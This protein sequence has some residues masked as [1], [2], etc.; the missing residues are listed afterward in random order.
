M[1]RKLFFSATCLLFSHFAFSQGAAFDY[2]DDAFKYSD[3]TQN[4]TARFRGIGGNHAALGGD[5]SNLFGNPA[6]LA[7]YNRSELS[8]SPTFTSVNNQNT[9][10]GGQTSSGSGKLSIG[11]M[12]LVLPG[13]NNNNSS[14]WRRSAFGISYSQTANFFDYVDV[15]GLNNNPNSSIAQTYINDA[16]ASGISEND[17]LGGL[18][19]GNRRADF[20]TA[21]AYGLFLINP[22]TT[23]TPNYSGQPYTRYDATVQKDQR[24]TISRAGAHSQWTLSYAGNL[25]DKFYI[26]GSVALTRLKYTSE[27]IFLETPVNGR[28]FAN[29]GQTNRLNVT[30]NGINASVGFI[31]KVIPEVQIGGTLIS[32]TFSSANEAFS[33]TL[34]AVAKDPKLQLKSNYIDV[35]DPSNNFTYSLQTPL[36]ASGGA[37]YFLGGG[38]IG[39]LTATAEY[40]NYQGIRIRTTAFSNQQDNNDFKNDVKRFVQESYQNVINLRA[41]AEIRAGLFRVRGGVGYLPSAYKL[42]L[43]RV[44]KGDR[45]KLQL[46][47]GA[48]FR[49]DR[50]FADISGSYLTYKSGYSPF[51]LSDTDTPTVLTNNRST[52]VMLSMGVFF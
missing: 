19:I 24:S 26:G 50:F 5:A 33:Q 31:Y 41:G 29:Y 49:N 21:A 8:V 3:V 32:P 43:D 14:R 20:K 17:L 23:T 34:T 45:N 16:N 15:R 51:Q 2:A 18:D 25:D 1:T 12:G 52:N 10:L 36:R 13:R 46:S 7:F 6:G 38:K 22:T 11:Q 35:V 30:G 28:T 42:D 4:G 39:F 48:G 40:V 37:T 9:F 27:T 47:A 44:A